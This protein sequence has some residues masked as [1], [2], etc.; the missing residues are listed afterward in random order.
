MRCAGLAIALIVICFF[1]IVLVLGPGDDRV[2]ARHFF[3]AFPAIAILV[4]MGLA[5]VAN[6]YRETALRG[7]TIFMLFVNT[8]AVTKYLIP[9]F[10]LGRPHT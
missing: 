2:Q 8:I 6:Q 3:A 1:S 7:F 9:L 10:Y 5:E 4:T